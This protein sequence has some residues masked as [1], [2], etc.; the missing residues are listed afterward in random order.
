M[1]CVCLHQVLSSLGGKL[2]ILPNAVPL[3][4]LISP[5]LY[6]L[7]EW[8]LDISLRKAVYLFGD[9]FKTVIVVIAL[10]HSIFLGQLSN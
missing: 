1:L 4:L 6:T 9:L 5:F 8:F 2:V 10:K 7:R 3:N